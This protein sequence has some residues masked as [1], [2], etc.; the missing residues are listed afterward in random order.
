M[1]LICQCPTKGTDLSVPSQIEQDFIALQLNMR[2]RKRFDIQMSDRS[3][4][5]GDA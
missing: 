3:H 2:P 4:G 1:A 5:R